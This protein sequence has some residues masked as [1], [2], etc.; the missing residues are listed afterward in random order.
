MQQYNIQ[1]HLIYN[2]LPH[3]TIGTINSNVKLYV[4]DDFSG[5]GSLHAG[6]EVHGANGPYT[7]KRYQVDYYPHPQGRYVGLTLG[8]TSGHLYEV[9]VYP[10][11]EIQLNT[12]IAIE[13]IY[14]QE[15]KR[16]LMLNS[17]TF[18]FFL[19][20]KWSNLKVF[21]VYDG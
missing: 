4:T 18:R 9:E 19:H 14:G 1:H 15:D 13:A 20:C 5:A 2:T 11:G 6:V 10:T 8:A 12:C 7:A 17:I 16:G 3:P 21:I